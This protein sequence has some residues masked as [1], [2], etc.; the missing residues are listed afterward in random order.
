MI[1]ND[2][3]NSRLLKLL[4][5]WLKLFCLAYL[6]LH[7]HPYL[8]NHL[9]MKNVII[10]A[11]LSLSIGGGIGFIGA[12]LA[13][14]QHSESPDSASPVVEF[15]NSAAPNSAY[16]VS[17]PPDSESPDPPPPDS[18]FPDFHHFLNW[19][20]GTQI[21]ILVLGG[22]GIFKLEDSMRTIKVTDEF[23]MP[24]LN[25]E[26][27]VCIRTNPSAHEC[28]EPQDC[29]QLVLNIIDGRF[30]LSVYETC[31]SETVQMPVAHLN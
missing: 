1:V 26:G 27:L 15:P 7:Q 5:F 18:V 14:P 9:N 12:R 13:A 20:P 24:T 30:F 3:D 17:A 4:H 19:N 10:V 2:F 16:P 22:A 21:Y 6:L 23:E 28:W 31:S 25:D 11:M 8:I 29:L